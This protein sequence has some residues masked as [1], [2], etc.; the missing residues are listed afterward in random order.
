LKQNEEN[1]NHYLIALFLHI[2]GALGLEWTSVRRLRRAMTVEQ[3]RDWLTI[4]SGSA[5]VGMPSMLL[6]L[7]SGTLMTIT[8]W[9]AV[10]WVLVTLGAIV[11]LI[12]FTLAFSRRRIAAIGRAVDGKEGPVSSS[13]RRL[14]H[15]PLLWLPSKHVSPLPWA[16]SF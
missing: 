7:I 10:A 3:V 5:R 8:T 15:H 16:S 6:L 2:T 4:S 11:L 13:L 14:T 9:G 1:M 12:I